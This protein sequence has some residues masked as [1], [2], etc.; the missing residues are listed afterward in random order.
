MDENREERTPSIRGAFRDEAPE[1]TA[2]VVDTILDKPAVVEAPDTP[3]PDEPDT[4]DEQADGEWTIVEEEPPALTPEESA[5]LDSDSFWDE[6][7]RLD[8]R[9]RES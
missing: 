6:F 4:R 7:N 3:E 2:D 5:S 8:S 9:R 1:E